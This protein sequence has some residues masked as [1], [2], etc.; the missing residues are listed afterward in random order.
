MAK[1]VKSKI[2]PLKNGK[3]LVILSQDSSAWVVC[4][5]NCAARVPK[6]LCDKEEVVEFSLSHLEYWIQ[7]S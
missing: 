2:K 7:S 1:S 3:Y 5:H 4:G 6:T